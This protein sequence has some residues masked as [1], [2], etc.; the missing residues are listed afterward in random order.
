MSKSKNPQTQ[1]EFIIFK[2]ED[3]KVSVDVRMEENYV[4][5]TQDQFALL[6][7]VERPGITQQMC[8]RD[9][10]YLHQQSL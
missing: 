7:G 6:Y 8:I 1:T 3:E 4:W 5:L 10:D 9:R 2:T